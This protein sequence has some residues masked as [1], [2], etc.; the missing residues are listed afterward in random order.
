MINKPDR[1]T[2]T[3]IADLASGQQRYISD[4]VDYDRREISLSARRVLKA[5]KNKRKGGEKI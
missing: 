3:H 1:I 4:Y 5:L 2:L